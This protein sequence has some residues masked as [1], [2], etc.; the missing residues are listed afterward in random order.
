MEVCVCV[1]ARAIVKQLEL[2][3]SSKV[4]YTLARPKQL[5]A[6]AP[7]SSTFSART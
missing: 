1:C 5:Y 7:T 6:V 4:L 2:L 3:V